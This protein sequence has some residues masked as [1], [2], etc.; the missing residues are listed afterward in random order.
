MEQGMMLCELSLK[1]VV[2]QFNIDGI[3]TVYCEPLERGHVSEKATSYCSKTE[4]NSSAALYQ[5]STS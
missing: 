4:T 2:R 3:T 5:H 1:F